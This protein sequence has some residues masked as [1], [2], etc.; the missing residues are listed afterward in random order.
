MNKII[1]ICGRICAGKT[2]YAKNIAKDL[3]A[4]ILSFDEITLA[5]FGQHLGD[6]HDEI[7][8]KT[9]KY[10]YKKA[11]EILSVGINVILDWGFWKRE[12]RQFITK[13]FKDLNIN[14]EWHYIDVYENTWNNNI[15]NRN[16]AIKN[17]EESSYYLDDN[18][19]KK[20]N[21]H[22]EEPDPIEIDIWYKY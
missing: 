9:E 5:L 20:F 15:I 2:V 10:L 7:C 12:N 4:V 11:L 3:K 1:L 8:E 19:I 21:N 6:K 13:Y 22:F 16:M 14:V 18:I 17:N